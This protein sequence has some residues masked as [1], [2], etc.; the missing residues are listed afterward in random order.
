MSAFLRRAT[1]LQLLSSRRWN[2]RSSRLS[3]EAGGSIQRREEVWDDPTMD[4]EVKKVLDNQ[5][6]AIQSLA[7]ALEIASVYI[8]G[9]VQVDRGSTAVAIRTKARAAVDLLGAR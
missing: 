4:P 1:R 6:I 9:A 5:A 2:H 7:E 8:E 3:D